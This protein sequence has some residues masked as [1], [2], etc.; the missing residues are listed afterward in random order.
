VCNYV[1]LACQRFLDDLKQGIDRG[2]YFDEVAA[3]HAV[4]FFGF[5]RHTKGVWAR[6]KETAGF[7]LAPWQVFIVANLFGWYRL[8]TGYRRF[9]EAHIEVARKNGKS[10]FVAGI[11]LYMLLG[12]GEP[13]ADIYSAATTKEQAHIIFDE[14]FSM[15]GK[16]DF[17][18][19]RISKSGTQK[20]PINLHM[21]STS[22]KFGPLA[23]DSSKLDGLNVHCALLDELHEHPDR[24]LYDVLNTGT[25]SRSQPLIVSITT[26]GF[27]REGICWDQRQYGV[28]IV[29]GI[30]PDDS[31]FAYIA[32]LDDGDKWDEEKNWPKA[33]PNLGVSTSFDAIRPNFIKAQEQPAALNEFLRKHLNVWTASD[34]AYMNLGVWE[35]NCAAGENAN[36]VDQLK[37]AMERLKGRRC[38]GGLDLAEVQDCNAFVLIFPPC[39]LAAK[40]VCKPGYGFVECPPHSGM[41]RYLP[42]SEIGPMIDRKTASRTELMP[43]NH[44]M[45]TFQ[46]KDNKWS[47][48]SWFWIPDAYIKEREKNNRAPYS[49]WIRSGFITPTPGNAV[50]QEIIRNKIQE[51]R[52]MFRMGEIGYDAHGADWLGS[53]LVEDGIAMVKIPQY[54]I[55]LSIPCKSIAAFAVAGILEHF[56]NPVMRWMISNVQ[57]ILDSNGNQKADKNKSK[58][59]IDGV[60]AL[61]MAL[62]RA[63]AHPLPSNS[64]SPD[65]F[66]VRMI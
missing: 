32:T 18:S 38:Y 13:G 14:A 25:G 1:R 17:L 33:N 60:V 51:C 3:Q 46:E 21:E 62:G 26:A 65:R 52:Q 30:T 53:K 63:L 47:I 16:S 2:I 50:A 58:N 12:D 48:L 22:S 28:K 43:P 34:T 10:T 59:K 61:H 39:E 36:P 7:L 40:P 23:A 20:R 55:H 45:E 54:A 49:A 8:D 37:I 31:F 35:K 57:L 11:G 15:V 4:D 5:L 29:M 44:P 24:T 66:K 56:N 19:S 41:V 64:D 42:E 27:D 6:K 9:R